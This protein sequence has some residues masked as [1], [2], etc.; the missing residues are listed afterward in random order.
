MHDALADKWHWTV[1]DVE[2]VLLLND[3]KGVFHRADPGSDMGKVPILQRPG[4]QYA[5][6]GVSCVVA[7]DFNG[8]VLGC[9]HGA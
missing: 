1:L 7:A 6:M 2:P 8:N 4:F 3:G 9:P 5:A